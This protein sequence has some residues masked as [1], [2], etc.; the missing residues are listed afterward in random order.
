MLLLFC[1][2]CSKNVETINQED[3]RDL[4]NF[5][6]LLIRYG[7]FAYTLFGEKPCSIATYRKNLDFSYHSVIL[8]NGWRC[9]LKHNHLFPSKNFALRRIEITDH[10]P[11]SEFIVINKKSTLA[12]IENNIEVFHKTLKTQ[13]SAEKILNLMLS[14]NAYLKTIFNSELLGILLGYGTINAKSFEKRLNYS[15]AINELS[16]PPFKE[17]LNNLSPLSLLFVKGHPANVFKVDPS[18]SNQEISFLIEELNRLVAELDIFELAEADY[19]LEKT[20]SPIF[21]HIKNAPETLNLYKQYAQ[22]REK[23]NEAYHNQSIYDV[24]IKQ[25]MAL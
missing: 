4:S 22:D 7:D 1:V 19:L 9:W 12:A 14:D 3:K 17:N 11:I 6:E 24:T 15:T 21:A 8:E 20:P 16:S 13:A 2:S 10:M 25:W 5:F 18:Y 23:I